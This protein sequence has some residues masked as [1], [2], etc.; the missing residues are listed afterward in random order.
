MKVSIFPVLLLFLYLHSNAQQHDWENPAIIEI[1]K[2]APRADFFPFENQQIALINDIRK[3]SNH[4]SLDA[5]PF[6]GPSTF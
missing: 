4:L 3:S 5:P 6:L 1:N 2:C